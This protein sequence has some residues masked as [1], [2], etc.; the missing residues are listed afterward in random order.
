[1]SKQTPI[2]YD[3]V[4]DQVRHGSD[5]QSDS[6]MISQSISQ[7]QSHQLFHWAQSIQFVDN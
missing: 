1:M 4:I 5:L 6:S 7:R 2:E 3:S